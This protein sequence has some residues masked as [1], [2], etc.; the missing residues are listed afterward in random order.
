MRISGEKGLRGGF[1]FREKE[2][3]LGRGIDRDGVTLLGAA[4]DGAILEG[5]MTLDGVTLDCETVDC[6]TFDEID[7]KI[8]S[9]PFSFS[10]SLCF[11]LSPSLFSFPPSISF[12]G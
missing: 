4:L 5:V 3:G 12:V 9:F 2:G 10:L 1:D 11:T 6:I 8:I 7:P